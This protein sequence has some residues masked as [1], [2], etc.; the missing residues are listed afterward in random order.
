MQKAAFTLMEC[1]ANFI[2]ISGEVGLFWGLL[3][4]RAEGSGLGGL[5]VL[6]PFHAPSRTRAKPDRCDKIIQFPTFLSRVSGSTV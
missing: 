1:A 3:A 2:H 6:S 4:C 5:G